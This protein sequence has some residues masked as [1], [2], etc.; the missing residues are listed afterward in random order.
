MY[1]K[2]SHTFWKQFY[3]L[4]CELVKLWVGNVIPN[5]YIL[6]KLGQ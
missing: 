1:N 6:H 3:L 2:K 5:V 4:V